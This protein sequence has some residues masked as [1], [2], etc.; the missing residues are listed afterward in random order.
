[1]MEMPSCVRR[2]LEQ[3][4]VRRCELPFCVLHGSVRRSCAEVRT[5]ATTSSIRSTTLSSIDVFSDDVL[6]HVP[7]QVR[8]NPSSSSL[9][10]LVDFKVRGSGSG[11][12]TPEKFSAM[13]TRPPR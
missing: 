8:I 3:N 12:S 13:H 5:V 1:M 7:F 11:P 2:P 10:I 4:A 9:R 6:L